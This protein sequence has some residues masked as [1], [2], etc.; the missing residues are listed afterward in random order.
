MDELRA[1]R[2][3]MTTK[4]PGTRASGLDR[5]LQIVA[6]YD[7]VVLSAALA[8]LTILPENAGFQ[9]RL[10]SMI[11]VVASSRSS[12]K[13]VPTTHKFRSLCTGRLGY[14]LVAPLED[15]PE[16]PTTEPLLFEGHAYTVFT[17]QGEEVVFACEQ[18][19]GVIAEL[20]QDRPSPELSGAVALIRAS[21]A[22]VDAIA[23]RVEMTASNAPARDQ[24][25]LPN[26]SLAEL[27][28][29]VRWSSPEIEGLCEKAR[30]SM[31]VL[32]PLVVAMGE[33]SPR[34]WDDE[35]Q[36]IFKAVIRCDD[37]S[38]VV[39]PGQV[40][41]TLG[42]HLVDLVIAQGMGRE[43]GE[44]Y[45]DAIH[46]VVR[47]SALWLGG[48]PLPSP[49]G[50]SGIACLHEDL[51]KIDDDAVMILVTV[52]DPLDVAHPEEDPHW[53]PDEELAAKLDQRYLDIAAQ[54]RGLGRY[55]EIIFCLVPAIP[56]SRPFM[57]HEADLGGAAESILL[58]PASLQA[59]AFHER[60][61]LV[62]L[63]FAKSLRQ[64][65]ED[66]ML[67]SF[68]P[69][70]A[71]E[72]FRFN[73]HTFYFNDNRRP[74]A[75]SIEPGT[76]RRL[77]MELLEKQRRQ[78]AIQPQSSAEIEIVSASAEGL[79]VFRPRDPWGQPARLVR[80][81]GLDVW[82]L[83]APSVLLP[84]ELADFP[85]RLTDAVAYWVWRTASAIFE[86]KPPSPDQETQVG[87]F[88]ELENAADWKQI[89]PSDEEDDID[90]QLRPRT[91]EANL[92]IRPTWQ[93][94]LTQA[95]NEGERHLA[96]KIAGAL[97]ALL[98]PEHMSRER[99]VE[100]IERAAPLG[101][102]KMLLTMEINT[103]SL[104]GPDGGIPAWRKVSDWERGRI[105]DALADAYR[106][107]GHLPVPA[108]TPSAQN[109]I[110]QFAVAHFL[111]ALVEAVA[112][113]SPDGLLEKLMR[114]EEALLLASARRELLIPTRI[115]CF[116][117]VADVYS[118]MPEETMEIS[119]ASIS[120]RFLVEYVAA[121]P[122]AGTHSLSDSRYDHLLALAAGIAE[123]GSQ[124]D[125]TFYGLDD[126]KARI[127]PS[128][129]LGIAPGHYSESAALWS[130]G[131][132]V[133]AIEWAHER[134][135]EHWE[136]PPDEPHAPPEGW[137][138]A[139]FAEFAYSA[140]E[141][142]DLMEELADLAS[143]GEGSVVA[144]ARSDL[145]AELSRRIKRP[146]SRI[147]PI[148]KSLT[149]S[150]RSDFLKPDGIAKEEVYPW[151][152][153]RQLSL[154]RRPIVARGDA[155]IWGRR[156]IA[157]SS[158]YIVIQV[159]T[160][161]LT[162]HSPEMRALKSKLSTR[163][164]LEFEAVVAVEVGRCGLDVRRRVRKL[165]R[166]RLADH[167]QDLGDIDVLA[168]DSARKIVWAIE[169]KA[170]AVARTPWELA[171][172]LKDFSDPANGIPARHGRRLAWLRDHRADL[173]AFLGLGDLRGWRIEPLIVVEVDL[174]T[175]HLRP[176]SM[177]IVDLPGLETTLKPR[178]KPI[179]DE[180]MARSGQKPR[181]PIRG[182]RFAASRRL[183]GS[184]VPGKADQDVEAVPPGT[185]S[186]R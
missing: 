66:T 184:I 109:Q 74:N 69:L 56:P 31:S 99:L 57:L 131:M 101:R 118:S 103:A 117:D 44:R 68:S 167:G 100:V 149:Q 137:D 16:Y 180:A 17:G 62:L 13:L 77:R 72:A 130:A 38:V 186:A 164:G 59:I 76:G 147:E 116:A 122:P 51:L 41:Q 111:D 165:G 11:D 67:I 7:P 121:C 138:E 135:G 58:T 113:L 104:L 83:G 24:I 79:P 124:S 21:L 43:V 142:R 177:A 78:S 15:P 144:W 97:I 93:G 30:A 154:L 84:C 40:L 73:D 52:G 88:I 128:G 168:T 87:L 1:K 34:A 108:V 81:S 169:C 158:R 123:Y 75:V 42:H 175:L 20:E 161:R 96:W 102:R 106:Q 107:T 163:R 152:F 176:I 14:E 19:F 95:D 92:V 127:L 60:D 82:V 12:S 126:V 94:S 63:R 110:L 23:G 90:F 86:G 25:Y 162:A 48:E 49:F 159:G 35:D 119:Q 160:D 32:D 170:L 80:L 174:L 55:E 98:D 70:D 153:G 89:V 156:G 39:R 151:R 129:R 185:E 178:P 3:E 140:S 9:L 136:K 115:A 150:Q 171:S 148:V 145:M 64:L 18:L 71:F 91:R 50:S 54:V 26:R 155:L 143:E 139:F 134:F 173:A 114:L 4:S 45:T 27:A 5:L 8:G 29:P 2:R 146:E 37:G 181:A 61:P 112:E 6:P 33:V 125:I 10:E 157:T 133:R 166:A 22:L 179:T 120:H 47:E 28:R 53:F 183:L 105:R 182:S 141:L 132:T 85:E 65:Q 36:I 46:Q 172:E